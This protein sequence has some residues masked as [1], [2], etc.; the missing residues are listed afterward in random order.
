VCAACGT[1]RRRR[2]PAR[3]A[4]ST[5]SAHVTFENCNAQHVILSVTVPRHAFTPGETVTYTVRLSNTGT[6]TCG[7]ALAEI[8]Q[9]R[10]ALTVG[11]W[12]T[13]PTVFRNARGVNVFPGPV[14]YASP[15]EFG[16][17]LGPHS[18]ASTT[19]SWNQIEALGSPVHMQQAPPGTTGWWWARP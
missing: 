15:A 7:Q 4:P 10:R 14:A 19:G 17:R 5:S 13:L 8:P 9:A 12:G 6:T 2:P 11:P 1:R 3:S 18:S 16:F